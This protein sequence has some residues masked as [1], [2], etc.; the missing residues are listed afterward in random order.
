LDQTLFHPEGGGQ[1][2]DTGHLSVVDSDLALALGAADLPV[3]A[4]TEDDGEIVHWVHV[5][6]PPAYPL[7]SLPLTA[8]ARAG[9]E[10]RLDRRFDLMQQHT[11]QHILSRAFE[12]VRDARTV[13]FHSPPTT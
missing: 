11:G 2:Y 9:E 8:A 7:T 4:V 10:N 6:I 12:Q 3:V 5:D 1:P 13:G